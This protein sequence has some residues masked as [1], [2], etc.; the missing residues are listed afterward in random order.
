FQSITRYVIDRTKKVL[1]STQ[2]VIAASSMKAPPGLI[3]LRL[4]RAG[5]ASGG[6]NSSEMKMTKRSYPRHVPFIR[7]HP[8]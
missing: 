7:R 3:W 2:M 8:E 6:A 4:Q 5:V 1:Q